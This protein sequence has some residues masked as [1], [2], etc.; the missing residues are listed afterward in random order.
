LGYGGWYLPL[1]VKAH[2]SEWVTWTCPQNGESVARFGELGSQSGIVR[3]ND[4]ESTIRR[5]STRAAAAES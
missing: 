3:A 2:L 4:A 1:S 5:A